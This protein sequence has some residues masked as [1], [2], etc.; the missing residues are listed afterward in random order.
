MGLKKE[1]VLCI[2]IVFILVCVFALSYR[3]PKSLQDLEKIK[4][5]DRIS[6]TAGELT[7]L[8]ISKTDNASS[9][10]YLLKDD[11]NTRFVIVASQMPYIKRYE[12]TAP[13]S[14]MENEIFAPHDY[15]N[16]VTL[17][18]KNGTLQIE[19]SKHISVLLYII[20]CVLGIF[21][22]MHIPFQRLH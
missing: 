13:L 12:M 10:Y 6:T 5:D 7:V 16:K 22:L 9:W 4:I 3:Y 15:Y 18:V 2:D 21:L 17:V 20:P 19:T 1:Y 11:A 8:D 14:M